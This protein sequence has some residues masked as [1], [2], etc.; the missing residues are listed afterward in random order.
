MQRSESS[1]GC[2][3]TVS[4]D[5]SANIR[6]KDMYSRLYRIDNWIGDR[7][8]TCSR[9]CRPGISGIA[10]SVSSV[11][12]VGNVAVRFDIIESRTA[13]V[14]IFY[15]IRFSTDMLTG[16]EDCDRICYRL[17]RACDLIDVLGPDSWGGPCH[18]VSA[19]AIILRCIGV[20]LAGC[21]DDEKKKRE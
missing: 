1:G 13:I 19:A 17:K 18:S 3:C 16:V 9:E 20:L 2:Y 4:P 14:I 8:M 12:S 21:E 7:L 6:P 10:K 11:R 15:H 5:K